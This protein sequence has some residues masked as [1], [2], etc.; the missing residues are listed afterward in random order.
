MAGG[1]GR[2]LG[3]DSATGELSQAPRLG[4]GPLVA[5]GPR[6]SYS[7]NDG[8]QAPAKDRGAAVRPRQRLE[9]RPAGNAEAGERVGVA[10]P[11]D[12]YG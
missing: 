6:A 2:G 4:P 9:R 1:E 7:V 3:L 11:W 8:G 10:P 5:R 12:E